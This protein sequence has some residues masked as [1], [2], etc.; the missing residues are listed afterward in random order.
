MTDRSFRIGL[1]ARMDKSG[2]GYQTKA[3]YE[4][5]KPDKLL[6]IN[7]QPFNQ[8]VQFPGW[9]RD[10]EY[11]VSD[12][13]ITDELADTFLNDIDVV[14]T[15]EVPYNDN[16]YRMAR[17]RGIKTVLQPNAELNP[18]FRE[19]EMDK[20]DAFFLP[21]TWYEA[22]TRALGIPT[23]LCP[24]PIT[25]KPVDHEI[26][27]ENR[28]LKVLHISARAIHDRNGT[29]IV[30]RL[31]N[32]GGVT[33]D[34]HDQIINNVDNMEEIYRN[35]YH[36]VLLPRRYGG[37]CLPMLESL[38]LGIPVIMP[39]ISPNNDVLPAE[40]LVPAARGQRFPTKRLI[41]RYK[42]ND[43]EILAKLK[44][45]RDMDQ[46]QYDEER[47]KAMNIFDTYEYDLS[48]WN[49]YLEEVIK[50]S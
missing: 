27:K 3:L 17:E 25:I 43:R 13:F 12:G 7:S 22:E 4:L 47:K 44:W 29:Q 38:A 33:I 8:R 34:I 50:K 11:V 30:R 42:A 23:Y 6:V 15:C 32:L 21:S 36:V 9:Y 18:H 45:F 40:W 10:S 31:P 39:D 1:I 37:L 19:R 26:K 2:L 41:Y 48:L 24:P 20:P 49:T 14:I 16:L 28:Q 35:G 5:L 46:K